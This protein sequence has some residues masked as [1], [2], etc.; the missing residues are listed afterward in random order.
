MG[1]YARQ[2]VETLSRRWLHGLRSISTKLVLIYTRSTDC[3]ICLASEVEIVV[4]RQGAYDF[5]SRRVDFN[6]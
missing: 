4:E 6:R 1:G 2:S 3:C 5:G